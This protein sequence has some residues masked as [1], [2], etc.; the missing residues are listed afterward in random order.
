V[1]AKLRGATDS[2][3][4]GA[5]SDGRV[6]ATPE[7]NPSNFAA[8]AVTATSILLRWIAPAVGVRPAGY[9]VVYRVR[10]NATAQE[11][12]LPLEAAVALTSFVD[13]QQVAAPLPVPLWSP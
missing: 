1:Q 10:A 11:L 4:I 7:D 12:P 5:A 6:N 9:R 2:D 3:Y 13:T 8:I